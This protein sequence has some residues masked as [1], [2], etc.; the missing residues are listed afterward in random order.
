M[1]KTTITYQPRGT[2]GFTCTLTTSA[3]RRWSVAGVA[4]DPASA[5]EKAGLAIGNRWLMD[6]LWSYGKLEREYR[7]S[8]HEKTRKSLRKQTDKLGGEVREPPR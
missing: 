8:R 2:T 6:A 1:A 7:R 5:E 3:G 4:D